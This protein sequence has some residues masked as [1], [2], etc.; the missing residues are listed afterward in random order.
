[1]PPTA[2]NHYSVFARCPDCQAVSVFT[3]RHEAGEHGYLLVNVGHQFNNQTFTRIHWR[4]L[5]C[6]GCNRAGLAK[7]HDSGNGETA[8]LESFHPRALPSA[9]LPAGVPDGVVS[10]Y[11][12]A[13]LC[14]SGACGRRPLSARDQP[15]RVSGT[16]GSWRE[17]PKICTTLR[18]CS[19]DLR[20][21]GRP[22]MHGVWTPGAWW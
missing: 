12:E 19:N 14:A 1:M 11:R 2:I 9:P 3:H 13:E 15:T 4:L 22:I 8:V 7:F 20:R 18:A 21:R 10:E 17:T 16:R 5:K 6:S